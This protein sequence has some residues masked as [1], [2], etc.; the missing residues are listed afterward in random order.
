MPVSPPSAGPA[1]APAPGPLRLAQP[2]RLGVL[3]VAC[4]SEGQAAGTPLA[5]PAVAWLA[6]RGRGGGLALWRLAS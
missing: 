6:A 5:E 2:V 3:V 1:L 4:R